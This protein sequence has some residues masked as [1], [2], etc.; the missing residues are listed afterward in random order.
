VRTAVGGGAGRAES[1]LGPSSG[2]RA[3]WWTGR[4]PEPRLQAQEPLRRPGVRQICVKD[5]EMGLPEEVAE[6]RG[7]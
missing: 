7:K 6:K 5:Y 2:R 3:R 4:Q 1:A